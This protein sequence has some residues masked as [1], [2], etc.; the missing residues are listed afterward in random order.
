MSVHQY[1]VAVL[2][3]GEL[4]RQLLA[5]LVSHFESSFH[6][7][8]FSGQLVSFQLQ[9]CNRTVL[10]QYLRTSNTDMNHCCCC[11]HKWAIAMVSE[12]C[13]P[14]P[15]LVWTGSRFIS[16]NS[17]LH[18]DLFFSY[19]HFWQ[20]VYTFYQHFDSFFNEMLLL[21]FFTLSFLLAIFLNC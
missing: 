8:E 5:A 11:K 7:L 9:L 10:G 6:R 15:Q 14:D 16:L 12:H 4:F 13:G 18:S 3:R 19:C 20:V 21:L 2:Q 1:Q 17:E